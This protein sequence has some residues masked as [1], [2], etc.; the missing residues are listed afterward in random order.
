VA[1]A[2]GEVTGTIRIDGKQLV[3]GKITFYQ[4]NGQF[5]GS[6]I[7]D[8]KYKIDRVPAR[9]LRVTVEGKGVPLKYTSDETS[10]LVVEVV[11]GGPTVID[12]DLK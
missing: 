6:K 10:G 9:N 8:G 1:A 7:K 12:L 5:I 2:D 3:G 4:E 11:E